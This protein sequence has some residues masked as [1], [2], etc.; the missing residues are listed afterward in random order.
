MGR[1]RS[2]HEGGAGSLDCSGAALAPRVSRRRP[3]TRSGRARF[4]PT[5]GAGLISCLAAISV[6]AQIAINEVDYDQSGTDTADFVEL[7]EPGKTG[8][9]LAGWELALYNGTA[10]QR[11]PYLTISLSAAPGGVMPPDGYLVIGP[12]GIPEVDITLPSG[13]WIQNGS[14]D[15]MALVSSGV[16]VELWAYE[17]SFVGASGPAAGMTFEDIEVA[18]QGG[19]GLGLQRLPDGGAWAAIPEAAR[20]PGEPNPEGWGV[21]AYGGLTTMHLTDGLSGPIA[22]CADGGTPPY[23]LTII[24]L[25]SYG[26]LSDDGGAIT[27]TPAVVSGALIFAPDPGFSGVDTFEF[28][29]R[30]DMGLTAFPAVQ[31]IGVQQGVIDVVISEVMRQPSGDQRAFEYVEIH[32]PTAQTVSLGRLDSLPPLSANTVDNLAGQTIPPGATRILAPDARAESLE[33]ELLRCEWGLLET[34]II[35]VALA[36]WELLPSVSGIGCATPE[37]SRLLLYDS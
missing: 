1:V 18:E 23:V 22:L 29:A 21:I 26:D 32:N 13:G 12:A 8:L 34:E 14:P 15:G 11:S 37:P 35:R 16:V 3:T 28:T 19:D 4:L 20:T 25:P 24:S 36:N 10:S 7:F 5:L 31:E 17:G 33:L 27:V 9:S 2:C 30:D 6:S